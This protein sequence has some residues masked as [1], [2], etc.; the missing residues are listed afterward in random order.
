VAGAVL[1]AL[2][3]GRTPPLASA[4]VDRSVLAFTAAISML[5]AL[6]VGVLP[7]LYSRGPIRPRA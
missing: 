1:V 5:S 3:P 7:A 2:I 4:G 6:A